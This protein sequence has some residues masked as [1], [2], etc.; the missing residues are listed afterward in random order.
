MQK[1]DKS[2]LTLSYVLFSARRITSSLVIH[3]HEI[4]LWQISSE[5]LSLASHDDLN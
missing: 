1:K 4:V 2:D 5:I 3:V